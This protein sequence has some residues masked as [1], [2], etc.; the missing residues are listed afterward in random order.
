MHYLATTDYSDMTTA[1]SIMQ[2]VL[3]QTKEAKSSKSSGLVLFSC[4]PIQYQSSQ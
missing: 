1:C 4:L 2:E 3:S